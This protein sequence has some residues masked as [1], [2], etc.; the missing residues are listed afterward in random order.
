MEVVV[1]P[2]VSEISEAETKQVLRR[3]KEMGKALTPEEIIAQ[4]RSY[5][6]GCVA[7]DDP[8]LQKVVNKKLDEIYGPEE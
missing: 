2:N 6:L 4:R 7:G 8:E 1:L 5:V 3:L